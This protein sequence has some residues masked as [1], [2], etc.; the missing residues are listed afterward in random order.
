MI[1]RAVSHLS[2]ANTVATVALFVALGG[3]A[4]AATTLPRD[5]VGS[6]QIRA[7]AVS[8][9]E[10]A[11]AAVG[12]D[13]IARDAVTLHRL[14]PGVRRRL[15]AQASPSAQ[16]PAGAQGA[17]GD[18]GLPG[19]TGAPATLESASTTATDITNYQNGDTIGTAHSA[20]PGYYLAIASGTVANTGTSDDYLNC[21]FDVA[22]T[23]AGAAGFSTTAG[24]A[25]SGSSVTVA[26]T[27]SANEAV[28]FV[29]F[30][31][32]ATTFDISN[33]KMKLVKLADQ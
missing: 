3:G 1:R 19:P 15:Y 30:G 12:T 5:S 7:N 17:K 16:G 32:G 31:S 21:G 6:E 29:C 8:S 22:G 11:Y 33:I 27:T 2:Y 13:Q 24:N 9:S 20:G 18:A 14:S 23:I 26:P 28:R 10:L 25:T 4:Y